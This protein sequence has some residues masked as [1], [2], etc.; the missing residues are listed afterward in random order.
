MVEYR[1]AVHLPK[2]WCLSAKIRNTLIIKKMPRVEELPDDFDE[3]LKLD[4][5]EASSTATS[6]A[7]P[8]PIKPS[9]AAQDGPT[10]QLPPQM[11]SV[12]SYTADEIVQMM[13]KTPLFMTSL[14]SV[15]DGMLHLPNEV[16]EDS[17]LR[18]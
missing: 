8:F 4:E 17:Y 6:T 18:L 16:L 3:S 1:N 15:D 14:E 10:P 13:N 7:V 12:R 11:Q 9:S 2:V 5:P